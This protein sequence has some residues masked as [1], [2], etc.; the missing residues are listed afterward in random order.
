M[1]FFADIFPGHKKAKRRTTALSS[2]KELQD[3]LGT[4]NDVATREKI[5]SRVAL[6]QRRKSRRA[7]GREKAFAAG[8]IVG[9]QEARVQEMLD[10]AESASARFAETKRFWT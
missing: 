8:V 10:K 9:S 3:A 1:E 5:A 4:L 7:E 6:S 2:L